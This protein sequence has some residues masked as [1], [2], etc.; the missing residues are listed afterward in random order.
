MIRHILRLGLTII[1]LSSLPP[2]IAADSPSDF[3]KAIRNPV[4]ELDKVVRIESVSLALGP[5][6]L[7]IQE[8]LLIPATPV[9]GQVVELYFQGEATVRYSPVDPIEAD[10]MELFTGAPILAERI[11]SAIFVICNDSKMRS[12]LNHPAGKSIDEE[13]REQAETFFENWLTGPERQILGVDDALLLDAMDEPRYSSYFAGRLRGDD[14]NNL[15]VAMDPSEE[16]QVFI[17]HFTKYET[18]ERRRR[19]IQRAIHKQQSRGRLLGVTLED[20]GIFDIWVKTARTDLHG[21]TVEGGSPWEPTAYALDILVEDDGVTIQGTARIDLRPTG[22]GKKAVHLTMDP[23]LTVEEVRDGDG[24]LLFHVRSKN[25]LLVLLSDDLENRFSATIKIKYRGVALIKIRNKVFVLR[26][27]LGWY[28]SAPN[29]SR[30]TYDLTFHYPGRLNLLASGRLIEKGSKKKIRWQHRVLETPALGASFE[31]GD[32]QI[33]RLV[34]NNRI[35]VTVAFDRIADS[36]VREHRKEVLDTIR[37]TL[38]FYSAV[39]GPYPRTDLTVVTV[40][41]NYAQSLPGFITLPDLMMMNLRRFWWMFEDRRMLV[42]HE[43]AHQWWGNL[44]GWRTYHDTWIS[45]A[46]ADYSATQW[47]ENRLPKGEPRKSVTQNWTTE[48]G[49]FLPNGRTVES[50]GPITLGTRLNSSLS[51]SAYESII[52]K[53][54]A[55]VLNMLGNEYGDGVFLEVLAKVAIAGSGKLLSTDDFI[56]LVEEASG[57]DLEWFAD[58]YIKNTGMT[59]VYYSYSF[60]ETP[61]G[62]WDVQGTV[63]QHSPYHWKYEIVRLDDGRFDLRRQAVMRIDVEQSVLNVPIVVSVIDTADQQHATARKRLRTEN[64]TG[65]VQANALIEARFLMQG[66]SHGFSMLLDDQPTKL[67]LDPRKEVFGMFIS[68]NQAPRHVEFYRGMHALATGDANTAIERMKRA[69]EE[70]SSQGSGDQE[71]SFETKLGSRL[72]NTIHVEM[73]WIHMDRDELDQAASQID[74]IKGSADRKTSRSSVKRLVR[75]LEARLRILQGDTQAAVDLLLNS[76]KRLRYQSNAAYALLAIAARQTGDDEIADMAAE[77]AK[78]RGIK[79]DLL[80][81]LEE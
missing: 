71:D 48:L 17:G 18:K 5:F 42:A 22:L 7:D 58:Q 34:V 1:A 41:R 52:Y 44:V 64:G 56:G 33:E 16:E 80:E 81:I 38:E 46:M 9:N 51:S 28:P 14:H 25:N 31:I 50:L 24:K 36:G 12:L 37:D 21:N 53:K 65:E 60:E 69:L 66:A 68:A 55:V 26:N 78:Q 61:E 10:Q 43:M 4:L 6:T 49:A 19:K 2:G 45:E 47:A 8:G 74:L 70:S 59:T 32:Y 23:D 75:I 79:T 57:S 40:P 11:T 27:T 72:E 3:L 54:G 62:K 67:K 20:L 76:R 35:A 39:F 13:S 73:A 63:I 30:G 15:L 77:K 29:L